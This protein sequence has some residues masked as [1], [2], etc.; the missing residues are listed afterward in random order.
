MNI[1]INFPILFE[2]IH[3]REP[4]PNAK[5]DPIPRITIMKIFDILTKSGQTR[6]NANINPVVIK[7][8]PVIFAKIISPLLS[9]LSA[10]CRFFGI[11]SV[12]AKLWVILRPR[13]IISIKNIRL[14]CK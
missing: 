7:I 14:F 12:K 5:T 1:A 9:Q 3:N 6:F 10:I 2:L 8:K 13:L 4:I 11:L